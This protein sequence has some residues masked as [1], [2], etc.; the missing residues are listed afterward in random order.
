MHD[1]SGNFRWNYYF[2]FQVILFALLGSLPHDSLR[3]ETIK[4]KLFVVH[5]VDEKET[6]FSISRRYG[7]T[8]PGILEQNPTADGGLE[9]GQILK[10][11]YTPGAKGQPAVQ[12]ADGLIHKVGAKETLFSIAR[13][14]G[15]SVDEVKEWNNLKDNSLSMGQSLLIKKKSSEEVVEVKSPQP[16]AAK[17]HVVAPKETL[18]SISR[19][20]GMT[21]QRLKELNGIQDND[22]KVGQV[23]T[24]VVT[25]SPVAIGSTT[26]DNGTIKISEGSGGS[27]EVKEIGMAELIEGSEGNRKYLAQHRTVSPGTILKI[28]NLATNQEVFVRITGTIPSSDP[29]TII[30]ISKSAFNRLG[31]TEAR[32][33]TEITYYK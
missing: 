20:Y 7:T 29:K 3:M 10:I 12:T 18:F 14:Y 8:I 26:Q 13:L 19:L 23:L 32:F 9:V 11:P 4:G 30:C 28:R 16:S 21:V 31:A 15:V 24:V 22:L 1:G 27:S 6:L 17:T 33:K 5:Q 2:M 25:V